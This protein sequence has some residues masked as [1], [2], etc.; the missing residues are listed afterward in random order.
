MYGPRASSLFRLRVLSNSIPSALTSSQRIRAFTSQIANEE[1]ADL[2]SPYKLGKFNLSHRI[3]LAPMTRCRA[4][5]NLPNEALAKYYEQRTTEGGLLITEGTI[6]SKTGDGY[7]HV[8]GIFTD[9]QVEAWK[10]VTEAVHAKG[11][12]ILCQLWH[13]GRASHPAYQPDGKSPVSSTNKP[14]SSQWKLVLPDYTMSEYPPPRALETSEIPGV[15]EEFRRGA[16]NAI[17]AGFDGIEIHGAQGYIIDQ[18]LKDTINDRTDE[19]GGS[20]E[21]RCR[22][23][24]EIVQAIVSAIGVERTALRISPAIDFLDARDT[25]PLGLGLA[26]VERLNK[27]QENVGGKLIHIHS[28]QPRFMTPEPKPVSEDEGAQLLKKIRHAYQGTFMSS[29]G[30]TKQLGMEAVADGDTDLVSYG[31][32]FLANPDLVKRFKLDAP[33]NQYDRSTFYTHDP[34]VGYTDYPFLE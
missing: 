29:G 18:F 8:P 7:P 9:E 10:Q 33:L 11:G 28:I 20:L 17:R 12:I 31:R 24:M 26:I 13:V 27:F 1:S 2:F 3:V 5:D 6:V 19:Y 34:V 32:I 30:Y 25:D 22:F 14:I 4:I 23:L 15:V 16:V 21:N